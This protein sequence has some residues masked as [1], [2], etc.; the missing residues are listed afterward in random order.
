MYFSTNTGN[1]IH[2]WRQRFPDGTPEQITFGTTEEEGIDFAPDGRSFVTSIGNRQSTIWIH[3]S[4]GDRQITSEGYAFFPAISPDSK[5][6]YYLV[7]EGGA[8]NFISGGLWATELDTGRRHRLLPDF[9]MVHYSVSA[10]GQRLAFAAADENG[11]RRIWLASVDGRTEPRQLSAMNGLMAYFGAL[12]EIVFAGERNG[13]ISLYRIKDDGSGLQKIS[14]TPMLLPFGV[15]PDG[16]WVPAAEGPSPETRNALMVHPVGGGSPTLICRCYGTPN[17]TDGPQ[18]PQLSWTADR[19]FLYLKFE[20]S[21]YAI[22]LR[23]GQIL[24]AIPP[25]GYPS[26]EAV[27]ALPGARLLSEEPI[28][29]GP[30]PSVYAL[31]KVSTQR[32]IYRVPVP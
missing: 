13:V 30:N 8:R 31:M 18:P 21:M 29:P 1:G 17:V 4:S 12:D 9:R 23:P 11:N 19:K 22:P 2:A 20:N 15:S 27:A 7:R 26:K 24:P 28:Y 32:N 16:Q 5:T 14:P 10:D 6:V 25:S 3:D